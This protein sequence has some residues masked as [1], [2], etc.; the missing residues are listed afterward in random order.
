MKMI[1]EGHFRVCFHPITM[2]N[3]CTTYISWEIGS[4]NTQMSLHTH[5]CRNI[6]SENKGGG[7]KGR[8]ELF[9]KFICFGTG[10]FP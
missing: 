1:Q 4:Y 6:T 8:L 2:L 9:R 10:M 5:F 3:I 7:V